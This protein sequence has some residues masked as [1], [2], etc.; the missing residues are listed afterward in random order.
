MVS[1]TIGVTVWDT[2]VRITEHVVVR[3]GEP[4]LY[5]VFNRD[6]ARL[7]N[8]ILLIPWTVAGFWSIWTRKFDRMATSAQEKK[9]AMQRDGIIILRVVNAPI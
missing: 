5:C 9:S 6:V 2:A 7:E 4:Y 3:T 1:P 8:D